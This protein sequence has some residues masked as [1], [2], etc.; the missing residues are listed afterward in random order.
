MEVV[1][2]GNEEELVSFF[3]STGAIEVKVVDKH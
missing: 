1:V 3:Q 2:K